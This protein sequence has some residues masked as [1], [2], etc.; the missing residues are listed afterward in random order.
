[1][2]YSESLGGHWTPAPPGWRAVILV[3]PPSPNIDYENIEYEHIELPVLGWLTD[4][5]GEIWPLGVNPATHTVERIHFN[6]TD[7]EGDTDV[8]GPGQARH[9]YNCAGHLLA[10]EH[11]RHHRPDLFRNLYGNVLGEGEV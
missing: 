10:I 8:L 9:E 3:E 6:M 4:G 11:M 7:H 2:P 5:D 1:M